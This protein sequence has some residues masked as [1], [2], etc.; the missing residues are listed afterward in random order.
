MSEGRGYKVARK[1]VLFAVLMVLLPFTTRA[2][3]SSRTVAEMGYRV[4]GNLN[5]A[6]TV[7]GNDRCNSTIAK[8]AVR[9]ATA[10]VYGIPK[11]K[12]IVTA[13]GTMGYLVDSR[14]DEL[15][16][17]MV[18]KTRWGIILKMVPFEQWRE[19]LNQSGNVNDTA[20]IDYC[21]QHG[22]SIYLYPIP[23]SVDT[24]YLIYTTYG[25]HL[26]TD[27]NVVTVPAELYTPIEYMA[28]I[29][30]AV[31]A[32]KDDYAAKYM[33]LYKAITRT[34]PE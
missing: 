18:K 20:S 23:A 6:D 16:M 11:A 34:T 9:D 5:M 3:D 30:A 31:I 13:S 21:S 1:I 14:L 8:K 24:I 19:G 33:E 26:W 4:L 15:M 25:P 12:S 28:T 10:D 27:T 17:A 22:D 7:N 32:G 29:K 2:S